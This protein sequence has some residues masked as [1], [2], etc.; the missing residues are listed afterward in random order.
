MTTK[1]KTQGATKG[2]AAGMIDARDL[3][4]LISAVMNHPETP[5]SIY[6]ALGE[7]LTDMSNEVDYHTPEMVARTLAASASA[8]AKRKGGAK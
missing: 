6:N 4:A 3:P 7:V 5:T 1:K 2:K 8:E